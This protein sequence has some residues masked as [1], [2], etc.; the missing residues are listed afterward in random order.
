M[1][2]RKTLI[3]AIA[4]AALAVALSTAAVPSADACGYSSP[5]DMVRYA[6]Q[7]H[8]W[9]LGK[10]DRKALART[11]P[12]ASPAE[13]ERM[14]VNAPAE[15]HRLV[16]R[17]VTVKKTQ[18]TALVELRSAGVTRYLAVELTGKTYRWRVVS[19]APASNEAS[20]AMAMM[21]K[22]DALAVNLRQARASRALAKR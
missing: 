14:L 13:I 7:G 21:S 22:A 12:Q 2:Q 11:Y 16:V 19:T 9:M 6:V 8:F 4:A 5:E 3:T 10:R 1:T 17:H 15:K 18:A 20:L